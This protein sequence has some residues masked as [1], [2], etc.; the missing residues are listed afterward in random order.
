MKPVN[1]K[2]SR[3]RTDLF[4]NSKNKSLKFNFK[5]IAVAFIVIFILL[6]LA[7]QFGYT[8]GETAFKKGL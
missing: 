1:T 7:Y 8:V 3:E 5:N 2:T 4:Y 6:F